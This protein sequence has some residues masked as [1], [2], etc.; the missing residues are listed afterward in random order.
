MPG[1]YA[2]LLTWK[3]KSRRIMPR[4]RARVNKKTRLSGTRK[5]TCMFPGSL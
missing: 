3:R 1:Q 2:A 4:L 5:Q